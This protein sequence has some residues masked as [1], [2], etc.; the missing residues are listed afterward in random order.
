MEKL[1]RRIV[2]ILLMGVVFG[3][4]TSVVV[5]SSSGRN[6]RFYHGMEAA[7]LVDNN[8]LCGSAY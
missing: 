5:N 7:C 4:S 6:V 1:I 8:A 3:L 2:I